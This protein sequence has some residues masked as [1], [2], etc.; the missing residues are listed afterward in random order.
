VIG[1]LQPWSDPAATLLIGE[2][3]ES[4]VCAATYRM[5]QSAGALVEVGWNG[6]WGFDADESIGCRDQEIVS[7]RYAFVGGSRLDDSTAIDVEVLTLD[8]APIEQ[9]TLTLPDQA[10]EALM[11]IEPHCNGRP[12]VTE[13]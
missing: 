11:I 5:A 9:L 12:A 2:A 8:G 3:G 6:C 10:E 1:V 13:G 7:Y 4:G